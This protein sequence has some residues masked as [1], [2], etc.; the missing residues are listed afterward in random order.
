MDPL[1]TDTMNLWP[2]ALYFGAIMI[3]VAGMLGLGYSLGQRHTDPAT[4]EPYESGIVPTGDARLRLSAKF[5]L[6]AMLFVIFDLEAVF[7][8]AWAI[9][10]HEVG[11]AGYMGV[12]VFM[13][14]LVA[15]LVYEW[16]LGALDWGSARSS[17][18][19]SER[20]KP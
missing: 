11:W 14:I 1:P 10:F 16:R 13:A 18:Q 3:V 12:L 17:R 8:F 4:G 6:V 7:I 9:A 15:A 20:K 5:Y 19:P 2:L